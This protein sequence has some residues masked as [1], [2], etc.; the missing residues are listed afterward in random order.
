MTKKTHF[1]LW[2]IIALLVI[3]V[4]QFTKYLALQYLILNQPVEILPIF[5]LMLEHNLGAAFSFLNAMGSGWQ[6]WLFG[7]VSFVVSIGL[8]I[9]LWLISKSKILLPLGLS[10]VL[11]GALGNLIS[12]IINGHVIDFLD[13]HWGLY[14][15]PVFNLADSAIVLGAIILVVDII[16]LDHKN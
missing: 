3:I 2:L 5:N 6:N 8:I 16:C 10:F 11:G 1:V 12:R 15:W 4:D 7:S 13:F 9:W 14:H